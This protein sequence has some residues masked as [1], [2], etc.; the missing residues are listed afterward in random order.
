MLNEFVLECDW[1]KVLS[2]ANSSAGISAAKNQNRLI[3]VSLFP[4]SRNYLNNYYSSTNF[5]NLKKSFKPYD[6]AAAM[7]SYWLMSYGKGT[8]GV[9]NEPTGGASGAIPS[10]GFNPYGAF[11]WNVLPNWLWLLLLIAGGLYIYDKVK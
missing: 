9:G 8:S 5:V 11:N 7:Y 2:Y 1:N 10:T 6:C 4:L 3:D